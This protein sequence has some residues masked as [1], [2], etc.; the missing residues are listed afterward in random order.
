MRM[1]NVYRT[2]KMMHISHTLQ[3]EVDNYADAF[4]SDLEHNMS[5]FYLLKRE[6]VQYG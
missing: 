4:L 5:K 2:G 6:K 1:S 3:Q